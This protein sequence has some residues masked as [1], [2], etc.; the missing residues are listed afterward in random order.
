MAAD[1][2][3]EFQG[4]RHNR[5]H[6]LW[7]FVLNT[8]LVA[9]FVLGAIPMVAIA[10]GFVELVSRSQVRSAADWV[11]YGFAFTG[12]FLGA[13]F[14]AY[15]IKYYL[16]T[17]M[18]LLTTLVGSS[19]TVN[20][21]GSTG[22]TRRNGLSRIN[23]NGDG[24]GSGYQIDLG[25]HP[26]VSIHVAAYNEKRVI[27][28]LLDALDKL[29]YPEYEVV[30]V[31]DST[32][33]SVQILQQWRDRPRFKIL[34]RTSRKGYKGGALREALLVTDPR[35]E[36]IVVFDADSVPFPDSIP[37]LLPHFY[38]ISEG[39]GTRALESTFGTEDP[40]SEPGQIMRRNEIAAV[41]SYQWHVLNK[42]E[43]WLTEAVRAE[44]SGSYMIER[45]FQDAIGAL[46][47]VAGTA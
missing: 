35:T 42:S 38:R 17:T 33:E 24:N 43:S 7:S 2:P 34:H 45:P 11:G 8:I 27:E 23:G 12:L 13:V 36:Y 30:L 22:S 47:M 25:Y 37:R 16:S 14:F 9:A 15:A 6:P 3:P 20:G 29:E 4:A 41:Q 26:F 18:V 1:T 39:P 5:A 46:K 40:P 28:R 32:D 19:R 10:R 44:Y 31:D 21:H